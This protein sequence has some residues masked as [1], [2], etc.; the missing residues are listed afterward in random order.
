MMDNH[1]SLNQLHDLSDDKS[2]GEMS[3]AV[4]SNVEDKL[5]DTIDNDMHSS[6]AS[7]SN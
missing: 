3:G 4:H 2:G 1:S 5:F 7:V 6:D